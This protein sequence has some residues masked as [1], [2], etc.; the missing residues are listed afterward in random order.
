MLVT[1]PCID[2]NNYCPVQSVGY[3]FMLGLFSSR[4]AAKLQAD[5]F[6]G[7]FAAHSVLLLFSLYGDCLMTKH[8]YWPSLPKEA[9]RAYI[10]LFRCLQLTDSPVSELTLFISSQF[11][12]QQNTKKQQ[13]LSLISIVDISIIDDRHKIK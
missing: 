5:S 6:L 12:F 3:C 9:E 2:S 7:S 13:F 10:F 11:S 8:H 4:L 1:T